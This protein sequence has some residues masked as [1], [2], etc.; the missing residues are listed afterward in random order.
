MAQQRLRTTKRYSFLGLAT[1]RLDWLG[2][3]S[4]EAGAQSFSNLLGT[5]FSGRLTSWLCRSVCGTCRGSERQRELREGGFEAFLFDTDHMTLGLGYVKR[6]EKLQH[7][8][9]ARFLAF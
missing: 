7:K 9:V 3:S 6:S 1:L 5:S 8:Q 4:L 2:N